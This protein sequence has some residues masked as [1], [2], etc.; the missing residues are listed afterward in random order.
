MTLDNP[1][2]DTS[3]VGL[4]LQKYLSLFW[5]WAWLIV[6]VA[7]VTGAAAYYISKQM[8]PY[9]QSSTTLLVNVAPATQTA[10]YSSVIVSQQLTSTYAQM[11]TKDPVMTDVISTLN[12]TLTPGALKGLIAV[13][14]VSNT[15][16]I[17]ITVTSTDAKSAADIA[18]TVAIVF[19]K[20]I[21][22]IQSQRFAESK[23]TLETQLADTEQ[24]IA[25]Y[26]TQAASAT[27]AEEKDRL[28]NM[29]TQYREIYSGL[30]QSYETVRLSEAQSIS[31]VMQIE[32]ATPVYIP[33]KPKVMT[34]T[35]LAAIVG[36]MLAAGGVI[37]KDMLDDTIET[38]EEIVQRFRL[39]ILGVINHYSNKEV[40]PITLT[41][42]NSPT[43][44]AYRTLR[45][46]VSY[47]S[48]DRPLRSLLIT[49]AEPGEGKTTT[50]TNLAVVMAQNGKQV[51]V[52]DC[53]LRHP[54]THVQFRL[55]NRKGMS[56]LFT[57]SSFVLDGSCQPAGVDNLSVVT[58]GSLPPNPAEL[59]GSQKM[60]SI[61]T[62]MTE[63]ADVVLVD[64]PPTLAVTDAAV[65]APIV[66]A[67]LLVVRPGKTRR[68]ALQQTLDSMQQVKANVVGVVLNDVTTSRSTYGYHYKY[69]RNYA[70]Y[71]KYYGGKHRKKKSG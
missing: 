34:N 1:P 53:D 61:L 57:Q 37:A 9:Y 43:A 41:D 40:S 12:L 54:R 30:L 69:Y 59:L 42:A 31:S 65:L 58:T 2:D 56:N 15:Q 5:H 55:N 32:V 49:S 3:E 38:P 19:A 60:K 68:R 50:L 33:I 7:V 46:K 63:A 45:T 17:R 28:D 44:E 11:I 70:A 62:A 13:T 48:I 64:S 6:L 21:Q 25:A 66:D 27:N 4:D 18:N 35:L 52:A 51:I 20:Q 47:T 22:D 29:V 39:P 71:Q 36:L 26:A 10:D 23:A 16:L 14:P 67:V 8:T 24:Q